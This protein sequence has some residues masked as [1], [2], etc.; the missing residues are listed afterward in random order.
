L[1]TFASA[2]AITRASRTFY[3]SAFACAA[4]L[5]CGL[6]ALP[7]RRKVRLRKAARQISASLALS[8]SAL[9]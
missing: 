4:S 3:T 7:E 8:L 9:Q 1:R 6:C 5:N 2:R